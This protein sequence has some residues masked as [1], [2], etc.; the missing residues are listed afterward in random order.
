MERSGYSA[1]LWSPIAVFFYPAIAALMVESQ[2]PVVFDRYSLALAS[3]DLWNLLLISLAIG[4]LIGGRERWLQLAYLLIAATSFVFPSNNQLQALTGL[5]LVLPAVRLLA[6]A[7]LLAVEYNRWRRSYLRPNGIVIAIASLLSVLALVDLALSASFRVAPPH[8]V[9]LPAKLR[10]D[11]D[12]SKLEG[13]DLILVGD[14]FVW[15]TG[16]ELGERFGDQLEQLY[17]RDHPHRS[18]YSLGVSGHSVSGYLDLLNLLPDEAS[19]E[20]VIVA[21]YP[22]DMP[23]RA[24]LERRIPE[25]FLAMGVGAPSLR[26]VGDRLSGLLVPSVDDYHEALIGDLDPRDPTFEAR[27]SLLLGQLGR[28]FERAQALSDQIPLLVIL[29]IMVDFR[30]YPLA[31]AHVRLALDAKEVGFRVLDLLPT[32]RKELTDGRSFRAAQYDNHFDATVHALVARELRR[33]LDAGMRDRVK[34][35]P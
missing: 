29:P 5:P 4:S 12:F 2:V 15:G 3:L 7:A 8:G 32:F 10:Q 16:V 19:A 35:I 34:P 14:S 6:G 22:N 33:A 23:P 1:L 13:R 27:W 9:A 26:V 25:I 11:Y 18:V 28:L 21:F 20:C 31:E 30:D 17:S 24:R